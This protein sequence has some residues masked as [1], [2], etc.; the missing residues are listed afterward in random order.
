MEVTGVP[1]SLEVVGGPQANNNIL[2]T[3]IYKA[4]KSLTPG[5]KITRVK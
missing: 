2:V 3:E 4:S 5:L 1:L